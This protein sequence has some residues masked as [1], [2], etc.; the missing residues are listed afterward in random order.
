MQWKYNDKLRLI[1]EDK[2]INECKQDKQLRSAQKSHIILFYQDNTTKSNNFVL[3]TMLHV[4]I[5]FY[6]QSLSIKQH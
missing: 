5:S 2:F 4:Y 3:K 6:T 1:P